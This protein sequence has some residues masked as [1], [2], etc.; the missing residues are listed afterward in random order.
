[1]AH[2]TEKY[3][4]DVVASIVDVVKF[5][6]S[7]KPAEGDCPFGKETADC[8]HYFLDLASK[9]G[10][11]THNYDNYVGEVIFGEGKP[12]AILAHLDV[13]PAGDGWSHPPFGGEIDDEVSDGGIGGMKI[14]GRGT[15]DDKG[16]AIATLYAM[17]ALKD[18]GFT[19]KRQIKFIVG[20]N[21]E[22]GWACLKHYE[23]VAE[24]PEEG[25]SPDASFPAIYAEKGIIHCNTYFPVSPDSFVSLSA[26]EAANMVCAKASAV[27]TEKSAKYVA[28]YEK[29]AEKQVSSDTTT[30]GKAEG[31][32]AAHIAKNGAKWEYDPAT[33]TITFT[34]KS[35]HGSTP[36]KG[37]NALEAL[38]DFASA[39]DAGCKK[40]YDLLCA[41]EYR[42]R[43]M[44]DETGLLTMSP[45]V[46]KI[47]DGALVVTTDIRFP[48]THKAEEVREA[49][50]KS[51][52]KF[53]FTH[54]QQPLYND[55]NGSLISTLMKVYNAHTGKNEKAI[56]IGGGTYARAL[57][58]GCGFGPEMEDEESTIHQAN[59]Y[60]TFDRIRMMCE[61]YYDCIKELTK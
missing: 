5:D 30:D 36:E 37:V 56:A 31:K 15:M 61:V 51:G 47:E 49:F 52:V 38:L 8:L 18:E 45:D 14:W 33:R 59:E 4:N 60:V 57:K 11:E 20:C 53:E 22:T 25:F 54:Y 12:L 46:A 6:T 40:A 32:R 28:D 42:L 1:M 26:G 23:E 55:P 34:G 10:F 13:V 3:F 35:A 43:E 9:M 48:A 50:E 2:A 21:E 17:K 7:L 24:M 19:P 27:L 29:N 58:C 39:F 41:D 44:R 16:P